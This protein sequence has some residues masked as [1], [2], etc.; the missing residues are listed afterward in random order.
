M[1]LTLVLFPF[2]PAK[3]PLAAQWHGPIPYMPESG[4]YQVTIIPA[5]KQRLIHH[6][7][8]GSLRGLVSAPSFHT[9]AAF[10]YIAAA[11]SSNRLRWPILLINFLMLLSIPI[12]GT[13]Y[14][15]DMIAGALVALVSWFTMRALLREKGGKAWKRSS[16]DAELERLSVV[17]ETA[18][19]G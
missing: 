4:L 8:L 12:E 16:K 10:L 13:H 15:A 7:M 2:I 11:W 5:L 1:I 18:R 17:R 3:G 9:T 14:L 6:V 19:A